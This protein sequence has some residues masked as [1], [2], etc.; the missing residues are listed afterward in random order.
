MPDPSD[1]EPEHLAHQ[2]ELARSAHLAGLA[3]QRVTELAR[4]VGGK[5]DHYTLDQLDHLASTLKGWAIRT[6]LG[7]GDTD[8]L[9]ELTGRRWTPIHSLDNLAHR[10]HQPHPGPEQDPDR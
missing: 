8:L 1:R 7:I 2:R 3:I 5:P 6:A 10:G 9:A 4:L